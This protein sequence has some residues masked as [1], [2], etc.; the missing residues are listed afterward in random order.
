PVA[1]GAP[2]VAMLRAV[3]RAVRQVAIRT[4]L[5]RCEALGRDTGGDV[6]LKPENLQRTGSYKVRGAF[7][8][9][10][11]LTAAERRRG[12]ITAAAANHA[13]G[14]AVAA[15]RLGVQATVV[16]PL[17]APIAKVAAARDLG[18][19]VV[20]HGETFEQA[21]SEARHLEQRRGLT[22]VHPFDDWD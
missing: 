3:A 7:A 1:P 22:F 14:V 2:S 5:L 11:R 15:A 13:Q 6:W 21:E 9:I 8:R 10:R 4:P 12:V 17:N 16:M 20:L 18:A 19:E